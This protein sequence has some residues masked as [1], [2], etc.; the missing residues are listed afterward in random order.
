MSLDL[1]IPKYLQRMFLGLKREA[2]YSRGLPFWFTCPNGYW[3]WVSFKTKAYPSALFPPNA[4]QISSKDHGDAKNYTLWWLW[5]LNLGGLTCISWHSEISHLILKMCHLNSPTFRF[6][7]KKF[8]MR[9]MK[10]ANLF[11]FLDCVFKINILS[12]DK[13][14]NMLL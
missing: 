4:A 14:T 7:Y 1:I 9:I 3:L 11:Y 6:M 13:I 8:Y 5:W 2:S 12:T 10:S